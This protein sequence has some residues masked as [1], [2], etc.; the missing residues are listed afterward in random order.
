[1]AEPSAKRSRTSLGVAKKAE[2][3]DYIAK[4]PQ[5]SQGDVGRQF[6]VGQSSTSKIIKNKESILVLVTSG[7][8]DVKKNR[9]SNFP[10][11][12][13][14]LEKFYEACVAKEFRALSY[15]MMITQAQK[16][17]EELIAQSMVE[18]EHLP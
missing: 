9:A 6:G 17:G 8:K 3:L 11:L 14:G 12:E 7:T 16:I 15:D 10:L 2:I 4:H 1:M 13:Q 5:A 18:K